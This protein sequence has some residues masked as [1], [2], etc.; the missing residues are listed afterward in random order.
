LLPPL[1]RS[2]LFFR[3]IPIP[4]LLAN[5]LFES[6]ENQEVMVD[7]GTYVLYD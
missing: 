4:Q 7:I 2:T 6:A 3:L 5:L 1:L